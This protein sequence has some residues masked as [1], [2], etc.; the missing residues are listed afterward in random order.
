VSLYQWQVKVVC[1]PRKGRFRQCKVMP[2]EQKKQRALTLLERLIKRFPNARIELEC[3]E[4]DPWQLLVAVCLSAQTTDKQVNRVTPALFAAYP[5]VIAMAQAQ[6]ADIEP[7]VHSL[8]FFRNKARNLVLA[9]RALVQEHNGQVPRSRKQLQQLPGVGPKSAAAIVSNAFGEQAIAVDT[10][11]GRIAR[12]LGLSQSQ[13]PNRVEADLTALLP[14][15][16][17]LQAHHTLIWHGRR[18]CHARK[19]ACKLCPVQ[20]LCLRVGVID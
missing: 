11:V 14:K 15:H 5:T 18:I 17:L 7:Y 9:A 2:S 20:T 1:L 19:P 16:K 4:G 8:G 10:H 6:P 13:N 3:K 12:R